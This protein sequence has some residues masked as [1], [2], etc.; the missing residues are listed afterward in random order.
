MRYSF[1]TTD[2]FIKNRR[3]YKESLPQDAV[4]VFASNLALPTNADGSWGSIQNSTFYYLTGIDQEDCYLIITPETE[5]LFIKESSDDIKLWEGAKLSRSE[6]Q[7]ISGIKNIFWLT[8]FWGKLTE[9]LKEKNEL[10]LYRDTIQKSK[11]KSFKSNNERLFDQVFEQFPHLEIRNQEKLVNQLR[12]VKEDAEIEAIQKAIGITHQGLIKA[13]K[14]IRPGRY[15][16]E[17]EAE[18]SYAF[19]MNRSRF[20]AFPPIVAS[21][22]NSCILHYVENNRRLRDGELLLID[23]GAEYANYKGDI[24]RVLPVNGKFSER[25]AA[26]YSSVLNVLK[27][28]QK[29]MK[30]G[31]TI[32]ELKKETIELISEEIVNLGLTTGA[33]LKAD[34]KIVLKYFPHGVS[35]SL[36]LDVHDVGDKTTRLTKG[37]VLTCEPGIYIQ[38]EN[39]GIRLE[40]DILIT[41]T[42]N[43]NLSAEI[44]IEMEEIEKLML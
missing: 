15:E 28:V 29:S 41:D 31:N 32:D 27:S 5:L 17:I 25:Q 39:I 20:H 1:L 11:F 19:T 9:I 22:L 23:F 42:G 33:A 30:P 40:N 3:K 8:E 44:P 12:M 21:G 2:L 36:G 26:V 13:A 38:E 6:A 7:Q 16:F 10:Y 4:S 34:P 43:I 18:I 35:H 14:A 37:M 24:T